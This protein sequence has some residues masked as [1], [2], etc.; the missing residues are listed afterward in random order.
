MSYIIGVAGGSAS[1]KSELADYIKSQFEQDAVVISL[2]NFYLRKAARPSH[3]S[4]DDPNALEWPLIIDMLIKLKQGKQAI[5]PVYDFSHSDR[6]N[7]T[8][9]IQPKSIVIIE[10]LWALNKRICHLINLKIF[11]DASSEIRFTRRLNR[12]T[13]ERGRSPES[14]KSVWPEVESF[15]SKYVEPQKVEP[16][17]NII[18]NNSNAHPLNI[19]SSV[20][21][22]IKNIKIILSSLSLMP[23]HYNPNQRPYFFSYLSKQKNKSCSPT[24]FANAIWLWSSSKNQMNTALYQLIIWSISTHQPIDVERVEQQCA[25]YQIS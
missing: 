1:G 2:D 19:N 4:F 6:T 14:V 25:L 23:R 7:K 20:A 12:D 9:T 11:V 15:A 16:Q 3:L 5:I 10:G 21:A 18:S 24:A 13:L 22:L 17:V 8:I